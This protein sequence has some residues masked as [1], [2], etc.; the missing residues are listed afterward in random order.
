MVRL[1]SAQL[2]PG[3]CRAF[4]WLAS[5]PATTV[6]E[7]ATEATA[8]DIYLALGVV[9]RAVANTMVGLESAHCN[10]C[11]SR[12]IHGSLVD[13]GRANDDILH[14]QVTRCAYHLFVGT[15]QCTP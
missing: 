9:A 10:L 12:T 8:I 1:H 3:N 2:R 5:V 15:L 7:V 6:H 11:V 14:N 13:V 4:A